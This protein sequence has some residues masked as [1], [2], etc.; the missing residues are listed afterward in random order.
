M[1]PRFGALP[2]LLLIPL[3]LRGGHGL[4]L[5]AVRERR[6]AW[7]LA[8]L[9]ALASWMLAIHVMGLV[10]HSYYIGL[11]AGTL[12]AAAIGYST[13]VFPKPEVEEGPPVSPWMFAGAILAIALLL[14]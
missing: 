14:G 4:A 5:L 3:I 10:S 8:P 13:K 1:M 11:F 12:V 6:L 2:I 9:I 7:F